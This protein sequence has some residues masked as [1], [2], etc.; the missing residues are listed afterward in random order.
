MARREGG[1]GADDIV[2]D[3]VEG[4]AKYLPLATA[5]SKA[6]ISTGS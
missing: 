2:D 1:D 3:V 6:G 4:Q 5:R